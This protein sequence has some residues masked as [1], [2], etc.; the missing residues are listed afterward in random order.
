MEIL[1]NFIKEWGYVAVFLGALVEGESIILT[2]S[3]LAYA[4]FLDIYTVAVV[5]FVATVFSE[6]SLYFVGRYYGPSLFDRFPRF[7][8]AADKAFLILKRID[9]W[10]ILT[11]RF[12]YGIRTISPLVIGASG[13]TL[14]K[15]IPLNLLAALIW[16]SLSCA[17][18]YYLGELIIENVDY[19]KKLSQNIGLVSIIIFVVVTGIIFYVKYKKAH[20]VQQK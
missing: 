8:P 15:F 13:I 4:G 12:I 18:G 17:A 2:A 6:Q 1:I 16:A 14:Q 10:F 5:A 19:L 20:S 7:K 11:C 9:V 3:A